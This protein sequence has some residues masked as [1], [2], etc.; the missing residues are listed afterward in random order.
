M[1]KIIFSSLILSL[2]A[3]AAIAQ[4][5][6]PKSRNAPSQQTIDEPTEQQPT[7][8]Y[9]NTSGTLTRSGYTYDYRTYKLPS[10]LELSQDIELYNTNVKYLDV[11]WDRKEGEMTYTEA[12]GHEPWSYYISYRSQTLDQLRD[13]VAGCFTTYQKTLLRGNLMHV[14]A[15]VDPDTGNVSDV[16]FIF[17]W[18][19]PFV[20]IPV[21]TYRSIELA[22]K[23][24]L[25]I[26]ATD[27]GRKFN[28][29]DFM[30]RQ[31]F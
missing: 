29:I 16:Y 7:N 31:D 14:R 13:I 1:K 25:T 2:V 3:T 30:W 12:S 26:T 22:L 27:A 28:Y 8:Y 10:G 15:L 5:P 6:K 4:D 21:E 24:K 19:S 23:Q 17:D 20:N 11:E 9:P 18:N